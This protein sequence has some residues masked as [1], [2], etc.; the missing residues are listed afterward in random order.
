MS[1][2]RQN[3]VSSSISLLID[4]DILIDVGRGVPESIAYVKQKEQQYQIGISTIT[5]CDRRLF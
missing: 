3:G 4:T 2:E 1:A 5:Y